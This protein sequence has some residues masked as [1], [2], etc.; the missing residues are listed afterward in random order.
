LHLPANKILQFELST[1]I[2]TGKK[3]DHVDD[4]VHS[5]DISDAVAN[6]VFNLYQNLKT[7]QMISGRFN[8]VVQMDLLD[9]MGWSAGDIKD[10]VVARITRQMANS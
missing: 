2:D 8:T 9:A 5:K 4:G 10:D 7:A 3:I 1:L 6:A